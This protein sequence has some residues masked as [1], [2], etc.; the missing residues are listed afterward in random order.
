MDRTADQAQSAL[1]IVDDNNDF[2]SEGGKLYPAVKDFFDRHGTIETINRALEGA[3]RQG[4][5]VMRVSFSLPEGFW[6]D[7]ETQGILAAVKQADA[8]VTGSWGAE[9]SEVFSR[10]E[11]DIFI[12]GKTTLDAFA[13]TDLRAVL[14]ARGITRIALAGVLTNLCI[15]S[16]MRTAYDAGFDVVGLTD[17]S[18]ALTEEQH[19]GAVQND[20]PL[21]ARPLTVDSFLDSEQG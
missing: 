6:E 15:E 11:G 8:F 1:V 16:T 14:E 21:I 12:S 7:S 13:S 3:R 19:V 9:P 4:I 20:W 5:P 17:A 2:F 18:A 10:G